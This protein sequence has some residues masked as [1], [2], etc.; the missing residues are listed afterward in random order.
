[1]LP[2][3]VIPFSQGSIYLCCLLFEKKYYV[4]TL[5][6]YH[7]DSYVVAEA[8]NLL[9]A[10]MWKN[11]V[12]KVITATANSVI[13]VITIIIITVTTIMITTITVTTVTT[14]TITVIAVTIGTIITDTIIANITVTTITLTTITLKAYLKRPIYCEFFSKNLIFIFL[15]YSVESRVERSLH[16][17]CEASDKACS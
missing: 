11:P 8:A 14:I 13:T 1:M 6:S 4:F 16:C 5:S 9:L 7:R 10:V 15:S 2:I 17:S 3:S 12:N